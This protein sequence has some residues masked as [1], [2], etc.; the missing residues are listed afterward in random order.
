MHCEVRCALKASISDSIEFMNELD[1][2]DWARY[3]LSILIGVKGLLLL[4]SFRPPVPK[5]E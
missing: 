4:R 5:L 2:S 3:S 1:E